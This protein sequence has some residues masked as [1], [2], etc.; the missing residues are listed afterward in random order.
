[1]AGT[2]RRPSIG[3]LFTRMWHNTDDLDARFARRVM[4]GRYAWQEEGVLDASIPGPWIAEAEPGAS[5]VDNVHR[6]VG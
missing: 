3:E 2:L 4:D 6:T 1:M 5:Q